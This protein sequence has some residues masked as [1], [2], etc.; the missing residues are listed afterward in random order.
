M[1][2]KEYR[3]YD[4][5][6]KKLEKKLQKYDLVIMNN[7]SNNEIDI[8]NKDDYY[9][10]AIA[11]NELRIKHWQNIRIIANDKQDSKLDSIWNSMKKKI[12]NQ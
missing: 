7:I 12:E 9:E 3:R 5:E 11:L 4:K 1:A 10:V 8:K 6:K 2:R